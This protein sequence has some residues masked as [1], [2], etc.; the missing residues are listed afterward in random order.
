LSILTDNAIFYQYVVPLGTLLN[1]ELF[2]TNTPSLTGKIHTECFTLATGCRKA[3]K[4]DNPA[5]A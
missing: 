5:Q 1:N 2:S 3:S 4:V